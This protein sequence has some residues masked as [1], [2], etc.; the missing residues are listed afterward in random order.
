MYDLLGTKNCFTSKCK[1]MV[2]YHVKEKNK[3]LCFPDKDCLTCAF[4]CLLFL[5]SEIIDQYTGF[6]IRGVSLHAHAS[7]H[8]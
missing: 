2:R 8:A 3:Q 6:G 1:K 5:F 4:L 7:T